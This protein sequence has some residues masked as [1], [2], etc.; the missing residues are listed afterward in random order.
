MGSFRKRPFFFQFAYFKRILEREKKRRHA[1]SDN[2][3]EEDEGEEKGGASGDEAMDEPEAETKKPKKREP[4][5]L[6]ADEDVAES[7]ASGDTT[8]EAAS[9]GS[10]VTV[11]KEQL[12]NFQSALF[13]I[14]EELHAQQVPMADVRQKILSKTKLTEAEMMACV[15]Q[16][17]N[18]NKIMLASDILYLIWNAIVFSSCIFNLP[19]IWRI[20]ICPKEINILRKNLSQQCKPF[21]N[22]SSLPYI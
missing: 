6:K 9:T 19:S 16:M 14:F 1:D 10:D 15:E 3:E 7:S 18:D 8:A 11:S 12:T 2:E 17:T 4:K 20:W 5:R 22:Q 13:S 21:R